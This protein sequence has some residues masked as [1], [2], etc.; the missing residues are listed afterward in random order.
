MI[1]A[2]VNGYY[3]EY[4][5][6]HPQRPV[7]QVSMCVLIEHKLA[8]EEGRGLTPLFG[9]GNVQIRFPYPTKSPLNPRT[10]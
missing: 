10:V 9:E 3:I 4:A 2:N 7:T 1:C 5:V 8:H 6:F